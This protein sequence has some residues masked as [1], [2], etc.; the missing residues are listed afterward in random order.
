M[1]VIGGLV[2]SRLSGPQSAHGIGDHGPGEADTP[3]SPP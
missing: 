2:H 3:P 1:L